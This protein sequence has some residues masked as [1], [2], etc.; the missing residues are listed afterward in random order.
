MPPLRQQVERFYRL[1]WDARDLDAIPALLHDDCT[2][3]GSLGHTMRGHAALAGYVNMVHK[4][5]AEYRCTIEDL[6]VEAPRAFA[7][8]TFSGIHQ[9]EFLGFPP[10]GK[11]VSGYG[12]ALFTFSGEK[13]S[14]IWVLGDLKG[15]ER[16]L[17]TTQ[18]G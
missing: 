7:R 6:V 13:I 15:L 14:D 11:R 3:R 17:T 8:M 4:A 2:F 12:C 18:A 9:D 10:T 1:V 5:L 16:Q